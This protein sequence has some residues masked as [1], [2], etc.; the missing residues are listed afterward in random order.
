MTDVKTFGVSGS[1][2][3]NIKLFVRR[4][5][6]EILAYIVIAIMLILPIVGLWKVKLTNDDYFN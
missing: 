1:L 5:S 4:K 2:I 3:D 6:I